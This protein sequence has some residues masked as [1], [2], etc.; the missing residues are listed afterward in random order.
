MDK[1]RFYIWMA[2]FTLGFLKWGKSADLVKWH[3]KMEMYMRGIGW[4]ASLKVKGNYI[5]K[6]GIYIMEIEKVIRKKGLEHITSR[7]DAYIKGIFLK[8][9][10]M[11]KGKK[12]IK[13]EISTLEVII[14]ERDLVKEE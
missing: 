12:Y 11:V 13:M 2:I 14:K 8:A 7:M 5:T 9:N 10:T 4:M 6:V 3:T 1:E